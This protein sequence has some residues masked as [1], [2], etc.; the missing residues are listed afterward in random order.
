M[1]NV[2]KINVE[3]IEYT[4]QQ[5]ASI[6][7]TEV[8]SM[9]DTS[10]LM[11][12]LVDSKNNSVYAS[13]H[14]D[15]IKLRNGSVLTDELRSQISPL[16]REE[17]CILES[18]PVEDV[19]LASDGT[20]STETGRK[21]RYT[22]MIPVTEGMIFR[23]FTY[24][25]ANYLS[26]IAFDE[27]KNVVLSSSVV[28]TANA[29]REQVYRVPSG[30]S[31]I[32]FHSGGA[33]ADSASWIIKG[34]TIHDV[35][36]T[37][38]NAVDV[39]KRWFYG[40]IA[41]DNTW[42]YNYGNSPFHGVVI[43]VKPGDSIKI[44]GSSST[45][46]YA[47][48]KTF[49]Y[50][51]VNGDL[52]D[53]STEV[54]NRQSF[55]NGGNAVIVPSDTNYLWVPVLYNNT[56]TYTASSVLVNGVDMM[57]DI[58]ERIE[59]LTTTVPNIENMLTEIMPYVT[60]TVNEENSRA[61]RRENELAA[62]ISAEETRA[63]NVEN[64]IRSS[65]SS[66]TTDLNEISS[67]FDNW[68]DETD[69]IDNR[70]DAL[71]TTVDAQ[72]T[73]FDDFKDEVNDTIASYQ[74]LVMN[75]ASGATI[76][77]QP[78]NE[79]LESSNNVLKFKDRSS[80]TGKGYKIIRRTETLSTALIVPN[81]IYEIRYDMDVDANITMPSGCTLYFNGGSFSSISGISIVGNDTKIVFLNP[82]IGNY[83]QFSGLWNIDRDVLYDTEIF[84]NVSHTQREI[85]CMMTFS[86]VGKKCIFSKGNYYEIDKIYITSDFDFDFCGGT[87]YTKTGP[88]HTVDPNN[89]ADLEKYTF[90]T[91]VVEPLS[92]PYIRSAYVFYMEPWAET[93]IKRI[94]ISNLTIDGGF[95]DGNFDRSYPVNDQVTVKNVGSG[96]GDSE[97]L[98]VTAIQIFNVDFVRLYN[99]ELKDF[100]M[101]SYWDSSL[102]PP[103]EDTFIKR[104][105][106]YCISI[107]GY[108]YC[109]VE[110]CIVHGGCGDAIHLLPRKTPENFAIIKNN[111]AY[112]TMTGV[113]AFAI[114]DG[115]CLISG[116]YIESSGF[117]SFCYDSIIENN[118][119]KNTKSSACIDLSEGNIYRTKNVIVRNNTAENVKDS[120][121][122]LFG[123][124]VYI[125]NNTIKNDEMTNIKQAPAQ[126]GGYADFY[127][128]GSMVKCSGYT[129]QS[130]IYNFNNNIGSHTEDYGNIYIQNNQM[131]G[132]SILS[133]DNISLSLQYKNIHIENNY[134][135]V[136][137]F[138]AGTPV[139]SSI[140]NFIGYTSDEP[141]TVSKV[142]NLFIRNNI[143]KGSQRTN[144]GASVFAAMSFRNIC[145]GELEITNNKFEFGRSNIS[146]MSMLYN[147]IAYTQMFDKVSI[148][149]NTFDREFY[150]PIV[151]IN[152]TYGI[153]RYLNNSHGNMISPM[154]SAPYI[155]MDKTH[156][157]IS[158]T[159]IY[160]NVGDASYSVIDGKMSISVCTKAGITAEERK[161]GVNF[162]N[163]A[164]KYADGSI[165]YCRSR[166][167]FTS[168]K[169]PDTSSIEIGGTI[170][171]QYASGNI[172]LVK[173]GDSLA[174]F[175]TYPLQ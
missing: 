53:Y 37:L 128:I 68:Q 42:N 119:F 55:S 22:K 92:I 131:I 94:C 124:D 61:I 27:N 170:Q 65:V 107:N 29:T 71:E 142:Y 78:D 160:W 138:D 88:Y 57:K 67:Q 87:I 150:E 21:H 149:N 130:L 47:F 72:V 148:V 25:N 98:R 125:E 89:I 117:N 24:T 79:D 172:T 28:G 166:Y 33:V 169:E 49:S 147:P 7:S 18:K 2:T 36:P 145:S 84:K 105:Y 175:I 76:T 1:A 77:N 20:L 16:G 31:Y 97:N 151:F 99:V 56:A 168:E 85:E 59:S 133:I 62:S 164:I 108:K 115:R 174:E 66:L 104:Y 167:P 91:G 153:L 113:T 158:K 9:D 144:V 127:S 103:Q 4:L 19:Y 35:I 41:A 163:M 5:Y 141:V 48:F 45:I 10:T 159:G 123:N 112:N 46:Y 165:F 96:Q 44:S 74:P 23:F 109:E 50:P 81:T 136:S 134:C 93:S 120:F 43:K 140:E 118:H 38:L 8:S 3:D 111:R 58:N 30:I 171:E 106:I 73:A 60:N 64:S 11:N 173:I 139:D 13:S 132:K 137:F 122:R 34:E 26:V 70:L 114:M 12:A 100:Y 32:M 14:S 126:G 116:N 80:S 54:P 155:I 157:P 86:S 110:N 63:L 101:G 82:F 154:F 15:I 161:I 83:I 51:F 143:I 17:L 121:V 75:V 156:V 162:E 95:P 135:D 6:S 152:G 40:L 39:R 129:E 52:P 146:N 69:N 90:A 102:N